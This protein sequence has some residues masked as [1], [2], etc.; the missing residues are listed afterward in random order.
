MA[1]LDP[2]GLAEINTLIDYYME[3]ANIMRKAMIDLG[4]KVCVTVT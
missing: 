2:E 4:F 3:N 1:C